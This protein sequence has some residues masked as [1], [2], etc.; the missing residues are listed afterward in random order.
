MNEYH[1]NRENDLPETLFSKNI[2]NFTAHH[3]RHLG[4]NPLAQMVYELLYQYMV[5][6]QVIITSKGIKELQDRVK[7]RSP[8]FENNSWFLTGKEGFLINYK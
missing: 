7:T 2:V 6:H 1:V 3:K 8:S 4:R 5:M